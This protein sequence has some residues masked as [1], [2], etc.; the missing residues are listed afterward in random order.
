MITLNV[1][2]DKTINELTK[3]ELAT[4]HWPVVTREQF[5][6]ITPRTYKKLNKKGREQVCRNVFHYDDKPS[7]YWDAVFSYKPHNHMFVQHLVACAANPM[8]MINKHREYFSANMHINDKIQYGF[9]NFSEYLTEEGHE[10]NVLDYDVFGSP[11]IP[12]SFFYETVKDESGNEVSALK[13]I[14]DIADDEYNLDEYIILLPNSELAAAGF[15][16]MPDISLETLKNASACTDGINFAKSMFYRFD[17]EVLTW[18]FIVDYLRKHPYD[19]TN[20]VKMYLAWWW[21][22]NY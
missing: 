2:V 22:N 9:C 10:L 7:D 11:Y 12:K 3:D 14:H 16:E 4:V 21:T 15:Q 8:S 20:E 17:L 13:L 6:E 5:L 18:D 19:Y 1:Q